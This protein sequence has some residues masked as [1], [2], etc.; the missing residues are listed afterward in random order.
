MDLNNQIFLPT[1]IDEEVLEQINCHAH[2]VFHNYGRRNQ[3]D[4]IRIVQQIAEG[5]L[6]E[7]IAYER[8]HPFFVGLTPPDLQIYEA[9]QKSW[10]PDLRAEDLTFSVKG[11]TY[12]S[13]YGQTGKSRG[14]KMSWVF[15]YADKDGVGG[16]DKGIWGKHK[17]HLFVGVFIDKFRDGIGHIKAICPV[18]VLHQ[19]D[20]F[21]APRKADLAEIKK[22][23]YYEDLTIINYRE[24]QIHPD[25]LAII[26]AVCC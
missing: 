1:T 19:N 3:N 24:G 23:I 21:R 22:V 26:E 10:S 17:C 7:F 16:K 14:N 9:S 4:R 6:A 13:A 2:N 5:K 18:E 25:V 11:C 20:L 12:E 15:Q 8:L